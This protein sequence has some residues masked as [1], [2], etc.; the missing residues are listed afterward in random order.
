MKLYACLRCRKLDIKRQQA[1]FA[2]Q[3]ASRRENGLGR[4]PLLSGQPL[5]LLNVI[6]HDA[7]PA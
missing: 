1:K 7:A 5:Y 2:G 3:D 6:Y 4:W